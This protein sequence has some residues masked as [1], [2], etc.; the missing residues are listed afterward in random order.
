MALIN[1]LTNSDVLK[2]QTRLIVAMPDSSDLEN[3][4]VLYLLHGGS[5]N[6]AEWLSHTGILR[7]AQEK[8]I[9]VVMP[10]AGPSRWLNMA[11]G[12]DYGDYIVNELP[13]TI[14]RFFPRTSLKRKDTYIG[15]LSMGGGGA[16]ALALMYPEK[17]AAACILS[18][19]SVIPLEHLRSISGYPP[20]PGGDG[21]PSLP[22]IHLGVDDPDELAG[23][24]Y[25]V[26]HQS[27]KNIEENKP[28]PR[29]FHAV[30]T[31]DHAF[32]VG[33][34]LRKHF[35]SIENNPY[36]YEF[37]TERA[38]HTWEFWDK[39]IQVFLKSI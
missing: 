16:M 29:L 10:S 38:G 26:I 14:H 36:Q 9:A 25:D 37:H 35:M 12:S 27:M 31:E 39:Y 8:N 24:K 34:A 33:L 18:T 17:Y 19:S 7:Y 2:L 28:L 5:G 15:G 21:A 1:M 23:T 11:L 6:S 32:E 22:Q 3:I 4:P 30:G 13:E 20:P